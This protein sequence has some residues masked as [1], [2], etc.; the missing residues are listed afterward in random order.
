MIGI[1]PALWE[2][3]RESAS[4]S[5]S[6]DSESSATPIHGYIHEW[7]TLTISKY[8]HFIGN[9]IELVGSGSQPQ[10][11]LINQPSSWDRIADETVLRC[12][13]ISWSWRMGD[14]WDQWGS[15]SGTEEDHRLCQ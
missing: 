6:N 4:I 15:H 7:D 8:D 14:Q 1:H 13:D 12:H 9:T 5:I 11:E 10:L 3:S 2:A